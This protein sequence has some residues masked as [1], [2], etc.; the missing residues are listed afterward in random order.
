MKYRFILKENN[1]K[2][3]RLFFWFLF[4][5]HVAAAAVITLQTADKNILTGISVST[6]LY[7]FFAMLYFLFRDKRD[8][9]YK[10][11]FLLYIIHL[12]LWLLQS[13]FIPMAAVFLIIVFAESIKTKQMAVLIDAEGIMIKK[14][15]SAKKY[16][17]EEA[18]NVILKDGILTVDFINNRFIQSEIVAENFSANEAEFNTFCSRQINDATSSE[19]T[20]N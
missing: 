19:I 10:Y 5:L 12:N 13:A 9:F 8:G 1:E 4:Y 7:I 17:W 3:F 15:F 2:S 18:E 11:R 6:A 14:I 20:K 16:K